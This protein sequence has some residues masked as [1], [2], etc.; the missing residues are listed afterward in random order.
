MSFQIFSCAQGAV[1]HNMAVRD[2]QKEPEQ[3][4]AEIEVDV[5]KENAKAWDKMVSNKKQKIKSRVRTHPPHGN[6]RDTGAQVLIAP[7]LITAM[8]LAALLSIDCFKT[9]MTSTTKSLRDKV[10]R[11]LVG[12]D[13]LTAAGNTQHTACSSTNITLLLIHS[14]M[15]RILCTDI[16]PDI[17]CVCKR[18]Q[19][20]WHDV[21]SAFSV[22]GGFSSGSDSHPH[23]QL[24]NTTS[25]TSF[26]IIV[27][28]SCTST[29]R[30]C[31]RLTA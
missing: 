30:L 21:L 6:V 28:R 16:S 9:F 5:A 29:W 4:Q 11:A 14:S 20:L 8:L 7:A 15:R 13:G 24:N 22:Q 2:E 17:S 18:G 26:T 10:L 3:A 25:T 31:D 27:L 23:L 12:K 1:N 19:C